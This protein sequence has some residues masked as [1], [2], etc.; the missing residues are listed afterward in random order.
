M[1][2]TPDLLETVHEAAAAV[3]S[4]TELVPRTAMVLGTGFGALVPTIEIEVAIPFTDLPGFP[5]STVGS[6]SG[7]LV[8][9]LLAGTPVIAM[10]S[11]FYRYQEDTLQKATIPVRLLEHLGAQTLI[12]SS[13]S[14]VL[15]TDWRTGDLVLLDD[16]I[17]LLG[18]SPL[19]GPHVEELGPRFVDMSEPYDGELRALAIRASNNLELELRKG[20]YIALPGAELRTL[21]ECRMLRDLGADVMG[22]SI[23]PDVLV[24]RQ[25]DMR[26]LGMSIISDECFSVSPRQADMEDIP[27]LVRHVE[28]KLARLMIGI[29][30]QL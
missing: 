17:N 26:V 1:S 20:V 28:Q 29:V 12:V 7:E 5:E 22:S 23:V 21:A 27:S 18:D 19:I 8:L 13:T 24:A 14:S 25:M 6:P 10:Q 16:H 2:A 4:R 3:R 30:E 15:N 9:G 11:S